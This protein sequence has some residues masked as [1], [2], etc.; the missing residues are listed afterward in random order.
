[1]TGRGC[2]V[3]IGAVSLGVSLSMSSAQANCA[4]RGVRAPAR[5]LGAPPIDGDLSDWPDLGRHSVGGSA[6]ASFR[7]AY[8]PETDRGYLAI[9][10]EDD[11]LV[12]GGRWNVT[13]AADIYTWGGDPT[14]G[15]RSNRQSNPIQWAVV[16]AGPGSSLSTA[17]VSSPSLPPAQAYAAQ[18]LA[19]W[20]AVAWRHSSSASPTHR[21]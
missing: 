11:D 9:E 7:V 8:S 16:P 14:Q 15:C 12:V 4:A 5:L 10:V 21:M 13:D 2:A 20:A 17:S 18:W 3:L 19:G 6:P 1:M